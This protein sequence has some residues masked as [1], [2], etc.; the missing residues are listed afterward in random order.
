MLYSKNLAVVADHLL[1]LLMWPGGVMVRTLDSR[2]K[3]S[4]F[5]CRPFAFR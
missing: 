3:G 4:R 1:H 5:D 2:L